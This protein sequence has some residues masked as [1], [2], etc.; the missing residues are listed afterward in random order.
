MSYASLADWFQLSSV[1][2]AHFLSFLS[3]KI[4]CIEKLAKQMRASIYSKP[5]MAASTFRK[6]WC[7]RLTNAGFFTA[8]GAIYI[9]VSSVSR[10]GKRTLW[11][12]SGGKSTHH[13]WPPSQ[14]FD[15]WVLPL[16]FHPWPSQMHRG[17]VEQRL[18]WLVQRGSGEL[19][20][21]QKGQGGQQIGSS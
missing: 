20:R 17:C 12:A 18:S 11:E 1:F 14:P 15:L 3:L 7:F 13:S 19:Q 16:A 4:H 10:R 8:I 5:F 2:L 6:I 21:R 9:F